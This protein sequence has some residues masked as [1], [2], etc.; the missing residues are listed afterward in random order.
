MAQYPSRQIAKKVSDLDGEI[1]I[2]GISQILESFRGRSYMEL[3]TN[4]DVENK[5]LT[6]SSQAGLPDRTY[7]EVYLSHTS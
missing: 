6:S 5:L 2:L 3:K 1:S 7:S 4:S